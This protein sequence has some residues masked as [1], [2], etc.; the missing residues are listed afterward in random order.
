MLTIFLDIRLALRQMRRTPDF[1][2]VAL[3][4]L[5]LG[6]GATTAIFTLVYQVML[7]SLPIP[8]PEQIY[9]VGKRND[10]CVTSSI[11][12]PS[13]NLFSYDLYRSLNDSTP[14]SN[15]IAAVS[16][17][18]YVLS[19]RRSGDNGAIQ[20]LAAEFVSGNYFPLLGVHAFRGRLLVPNDDRPGAAPVAVLSYILWQTKLAADQHIV[21][22]TLL[23]NGHPVT[24]VGIAAP[25][26]LSER[27]Q[28]DPPGVS[29]PLALQPVFDPDQKLIEQPGM[30][31]LDLLTRISD[32][33]QV[34]AVQ[35]EVQTG[36]RRWITAH[37][38]MIQGA[39][40]KQIRDAITELAP[41][42]GGIND[43]RSQYEDNLQLLM[44]IA[45]FVLLIAC[46]NLANLL[47]VR[48]MARQGELA[49]RTALG[50]PRMRLIRQ[51]LVE[52][53]LLASC[54]GLL[55]LLVAYAGA[56]AILALAFKEVTVTPLS[57]TPSLP[58]LGFALS[59]S[60][61]TG[62]LFGSIPAWI[63]SQASP[64][65]AMR[66]IGRSTGDSSALPQRILVITQAGLSLVLLSTAGLLI[67][68]LRQLEHQNFGFETHER[69]VVSTDL[70]AAGY[71]IAKLPGLY[72]QIDNSFAILPGITQ[73]A[74]ATYGPMTGSG[75]K[76]GIWLPGESAEGRKAGYVYVSKDFFAA[77]GTRVLAGR[78]FSQ[79]DTASSEHV[80]V[81]NQAFVRGYLIGKQPVGMHFGP[82]PAL[83]NEYNIV[84]VVADTKYG[85]P[86]QP[87]GPMFFKP[88]TQMTIYPDAQSNAVEA[89]GHL[90]SN[91]FVQY[92]GDSS[93]AANEVR[94]ALHSI[95][96][97]IPILSL[98]NYEDQLGENFTQEN[99]VVQLTALFGAV[100]L[101]L[102]AVG[103]YGV[104]S[105]SVA[106]RTRDI[107]VRMALGATR[108][109][110]LVVVL[111]GALV[112]SGLGI[113]LGVP[114]SLLAGHLLAH[115]LYQTSTTQPEVLCFVAS[116]LLLASVVAAIVPAQRASAIDPVKALRI[117]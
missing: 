97:N 51:V 71:T 108:G 90:A 80:A 101:T 24:V 14:S 21:G 62:M 26:F 35:A 27:N 63:G 47:L 66:G 7:R 4:T 84:G 83:R 45:G 10:C 68:S 23:L 91:I 54:G 73:F 93:M 33:D 58:V 48:G 19:A 49:L 95:N 13:W 105:Y 50:A 40:T 5:A 9:K 29:L 102:A 32:R 59:L 36:L 55:G 11:Q 76:T 39:S 113:A 81:V 104:T 77:L 70:S 1:V 15:G 37:P 89:A 67:S 12:T 88:M 79:E 111:R 110:V 115:T 64:A 114:L 86:A 65:E 69:L 20:P 60:I 52:A 16:A 94:T 2:V 56:H 116:L 22:S 46:A 44:L 6:I 103:L 18:V 99:L 8:H 34:A 25:S 96:P 72:Q 92:R 3:L 87:V 98:L 41:A 43:L 100:A 107:G 78:G 75:W 74:Y 38:E 57:A 117:D 106:R 17:R 112:Q 31:W 30:H 28:T 82:D 61:C 53:L 85:D 42:S 109:S